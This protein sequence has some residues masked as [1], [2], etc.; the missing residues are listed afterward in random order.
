MRSALESVQSQYQSVC[1]VLV[2]ISE[3]VK[4]SVSKDNA[5]ILME[6][7]ELLAINDKDLNGNNYYY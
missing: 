4:D 5:T 1:S 3:I 6:L 7:Q 2:R